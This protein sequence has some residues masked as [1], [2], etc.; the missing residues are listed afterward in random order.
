MTEWLVACIWCSYIGGGGGGGGEGG[1]T[2]FTGEYCPR[3]DNI[4][5]GGQYS[6][7]NFVLGGQYSLV[8]NVRVVN[9]VPLDIL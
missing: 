7:V 3:G 8:N 6:P 5:Q 1:V 9:I 2:L 4:H